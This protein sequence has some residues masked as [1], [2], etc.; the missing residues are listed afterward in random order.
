LIPIAGA[1]QNTAT[2]GLSKQELAGV[3]RALR[4]MHENLTADGE[5][6]RTERSG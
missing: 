6:P 4:H 5:R 2:R 3:K 1:L